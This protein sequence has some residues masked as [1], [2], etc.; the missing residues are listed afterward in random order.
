MKSKCE[1]EAKE[2]GAL[3]QNRV[4]FFACQ[5]GV[6]HPRTVLLV[7]FSQG[8]GCFES[9]AAWLVQEEGYPGLRKARN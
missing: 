9:I 1:E 4:A 2:M 8:R 7:H 3:V 6:R 5:R